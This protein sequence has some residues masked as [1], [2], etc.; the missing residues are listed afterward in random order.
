MHPQESQ[1]QQKIIPLWVWGGERPQL[2]EARLAQPRGEEEVSGV[3]CNL[4]SEALST[5]SPLHTPAQ[6]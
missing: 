3:W 2:T 6:L 5:H 1:M 4:W